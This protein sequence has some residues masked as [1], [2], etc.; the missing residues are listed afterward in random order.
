MFRAMQGWAHAS[1]EAWALGFEAS[2]VIGLR[3]AKI[4]SGGKQAERE[5]RLMVDEKIRAA[6][7]LQTVMMTGGLGTTALSGTMKTLSHYRKKVAANNKR[8]R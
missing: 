7:E 6:M 4:A 2:S 1:A 5:A 8:L 3:V